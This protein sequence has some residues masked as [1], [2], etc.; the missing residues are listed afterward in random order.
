M[1]HHHWLQGTADAALESIENMCA[2]PAVRRAAW[3]WLVGT[4]NK[5]SLWV[6]INQNITDI[7]MGI[8]PY[9]IIRHRIGITFGEIYQQII[10]MIMVI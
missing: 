5:R 8:Y 4:S 7:I 3:L 2:L 1:S 6:E 10:D 9:G